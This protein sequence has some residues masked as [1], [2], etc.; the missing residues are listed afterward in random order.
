MIS[1]KELIKN[2]QEDLA[3]EKNKGLLN[4]FK[5]EHNIPISRQKNFEFTKGVNATSQ[6]KGRY[7]PYGFGEVWDAFPQFLIYLS[8]MSGSLRT[9]INKKSMLL[10]GNGF[11]DKALA[12]TIVNEKGETANDLLKRAC[13]D[14]IMFYGFNLHCNFNAFGRVTTIK[15]LPFEN[16]R[17]CEPDKNGDISE[18]VLVNRYDKYVTNPQKEITET[19]DL[20]TTDTKE[21]LSKLNLQRNEDGHLC[22][23]YKGQILYFYY[24]EAG[25]EYYPFPPYASVLQ[26]CENEGIIKN[27]K[28]NDIQERFRPQVIITKFGTSNP[29]EEQM[30]QDEA[31]YKQMMGENG[32]GAVLLYASNPESKPDINSIS[33]Q[34]LSKSYEYAEKSLQTN[35]F[36]TFDIPEEF[37]SF[38]GKS[39]FLG[40]SNKFKVLLDFVQKTIL[41]PMQQDLSRQFKKMFSIASFEGKTFENTDFTIEN[42]QVINKDEQTNIY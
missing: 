40:D 3:S 14:L 18:L 34:D 5:K 12:N 16:L 6:G 1:T 24:K 35:I 20:F 13:K 37:Y 8:K 33:L 15:I 22:T 17:Q 31:I 29:T 42:L 32:S 21:I 28:K 41:I 19:Y 27:S 26:D 30:K 23:D 7:L 9:A 4:K 11:A 25:S 39:D 10:F 2:A 38:M 36:R